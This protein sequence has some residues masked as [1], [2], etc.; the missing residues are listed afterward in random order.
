MMFYADRAFPSHD[1]EVINRPVH[2]GHARTP[3]AHWRAIVNSVAGAV[4]AFGPT[5]DLEQAS[6][7]ANKLMGCLEWQGLHV[8]PTKPTKEMVQASLAALRRH[9]RVIGG[10]MNV[11]E[12]HKWRLEQAVA[13][14]SDWRAA[15]DGWKTSRSNGAGRA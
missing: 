3:E 7:L 5:L 10:E 2:Y 8:V 12:K 15:R 11:E 1:P 6:D 14:G 9:N 13:A 4:A